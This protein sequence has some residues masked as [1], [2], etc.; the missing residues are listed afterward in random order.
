MGKKAMEEMELQGPVLY[1]INQHDVKNGDN[2]HV[3]V[4]LLLRY[5]HEKKAV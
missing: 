2:G 4:V 3:D 5:R 1:C